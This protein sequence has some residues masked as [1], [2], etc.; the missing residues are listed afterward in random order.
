[1]IIPATLDKSAIIELL[2]LPLADCSPLFEKAAAVKREI[3]GD[4]VYLRGL[5]EYS[6]VCSKNC[7]YCGIRKDNANV[8]RYT[9]TDEEVITAAQFAYNSGYGSIVLQA[10]EVSTPAHSQKITRI[11]QLINEV[12]NGKLGI[13]LSL[14]E[15]SAETLAEW[16]NAGAHRYLLR[17]ETSNPALYS[18]LH[19][20]DTHHRYIHRIDAIQLLCD[21]GYQVGTGVM[22]G[23]PFQTLEDLADDL[24]FFRNRDVDMIGMGP[25]IEHSDT[26]LYEHRSTLL[27]LQERF[28][29][30]LKMVALL[31]LLMPDINIAAT[32]AM[33][34]IDPIGREKAIQVGANVVMPNITPVQYRKS[35]LLYENKAC[36]EEAAVQ[37]KHCLER[38]ILSVNNK[39]GYGKWGDSQHFRRRD[40]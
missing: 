2:S 10:G 26:P 14:G 33:Q 19:P 22:I 40:N 34:T 39:I 21:S 31:R 5:I 28:E 8:E 7:H 12:A 16:R 6:N 35:Y 9:M 27:P 3:V 1:M 11:L 30:S 29:L 25:Y 23:L 18:K 15:Q 20:A 38:R 17:I 36:I 13:T 37:C 4:V 24:L 32:T